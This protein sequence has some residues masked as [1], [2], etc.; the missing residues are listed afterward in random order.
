[1]GIFRGPPC[2]LVK[3]VQ[4]LPG[5]GLYSGIFVMYLQNQPD[6]STGKTATIVFHAICLL[7]VQS[8]AHFISDLVAVILVIEVSD[9]S[10][11]TKNI[12]FLS[13]Q[14]CRHVSV[15]QFPW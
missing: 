11:C 7:Y 13:G 14:L 4:L 15:H 2:T 8:T 12:I 9:N 1:M 3:E 6:K 5:L 10:I